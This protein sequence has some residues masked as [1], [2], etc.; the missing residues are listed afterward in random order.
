M[1]LAPFEPDALALLAFAINHFGEGGHPM[2][3]AT[4]ASL[5]PFQPDYVA[6][7]LRKA[8]AHPNLD[9]A[10]ATLGRSILETI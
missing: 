3:E 9:P 8:L 4:A 10:A 5:A 2:A 7:C 6:E 1:N